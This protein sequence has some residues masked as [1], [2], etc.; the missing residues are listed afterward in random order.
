MTLKP[1]PHTDRPESDPAFD[2]VMQKLRAWPD[3]PAPDLAPSILAHLRA[4]RRLP[5]AIAAAFL[6]LIGGAFLMLRFSPAPKEAFVSVSDAFY[7]DPEI[8]EAPAS[9]SPRER[10]GVRAEDSA[11]PNTLVDS[12]LLNARAWLIRQQD[13][14]GGWTMGRTGAAAN[15]TVG[16]S[17]LAMLALLSSDENEAPVDSI[18]RGVD[19]LLAQQRDDGL[20]GPAITGSLYNHALACLALLRASATRALAPSEERALRAGLELLIRSQRPEGGWAYLRSRG[21]PNSSVTV[22]ATLVLMEATKRGLA[23]YSRSVEH[24]LAWLDK[25][26]DAEGRAG[27]RR[28]G[29]HPH[30]SETLTAAAALCFLERGTS[31]DPRVVRMI[32]NIRRDALGAPSLDLYRVFFQAAALRAD[33]EPDDEISAIAAR[34][35]HEQEREGA[36]AGSWPPL[37]RWSAAGGRVYSTALALLALSG[38]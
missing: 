27:Y 3:A 18:H 28:S 34:L 32:E 24:A 6:A 23:D 22:W 33:P 2:R 38:R 19:F 4:R 37:D 7:H 11:S 12:D 26:I 25:T 35:R 9:L 5:L 1:E 21:P 13:P 36:D 30:G 15:Y 29:D 20:F 17:A 10:V 31:Q 14:A 8:I 16:T